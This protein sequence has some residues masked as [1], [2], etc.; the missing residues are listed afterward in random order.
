[1]HP[2]QQTLPPQVDAQLQQPTLQYTPLETLPGAI[3]VDMEQ[4]E[5]APGPEQAPIEME[6]A[7]LDTPEEDDGRMTEDKRREKG[8]RGKAEGKRKDYFT[9]GSGSSSSGESEVEQQDRQRQ[10]DQW[11]LKRPGVVEVN[12]EA[13]KRQRNA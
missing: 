5:A 1:M 11:S 6:K 9:F 7:G 3:W 8:E 13:G 10:T 12:A 4:R 2:E